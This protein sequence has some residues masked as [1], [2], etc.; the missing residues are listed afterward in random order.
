MATVADQFAET[1]A[2]V[3]DRRPQLLDQRLAV[4]NLSPLFDTG[5]RVPQRQ[6]PLAAERRRVQFF[7]RRDDNLALLTVAGALGHSA[8]PSLPIM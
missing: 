8:M 2:A 3:L 7:L 6:K 4:A 1:L 5:Q